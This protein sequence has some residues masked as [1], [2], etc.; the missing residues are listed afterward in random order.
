MAKK[1]SVFDVDGIMRYEGDEMSRGEQVTFFAD[2]IKS[3]QV[4]SL[5]GHYGRTAEMYID[6]GLITRDGTVTKKGQEYAKDN[7]DVFGGY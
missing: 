2:G 4:Y 1:K 5:Q 7:S 3:R 6:Q